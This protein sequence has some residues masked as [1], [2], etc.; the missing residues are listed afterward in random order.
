MSE[1]FDIQIPTWGLAMEEGTI[2]QWLVSE[3]DSLS[4]GQEICEIE[5]S[6]IANVLEA[7]KAGIVRRILAHEG[8]TLPCQ[9]PIAIC[10]PESASD[11]D[12][13]AYIA[14]LGQATSSAASAGTSVEEA[15][16]DKVVEPT[17]VAAAPAPAAASAT[18]YDIPESL[19][20]G[21]DDSKVL[22]MPRARKLAASLAINLNQV[23]GTGR[24]GRISVDDV[25]KA[26]TDAGGSVAGGRASAPVAATSGGSGAD[27]SQVN[28][29]PIARRLAKQLG[30]N[31]NDCQ[32]TGSRGRVAKSDVEAAA[33]RLGKTPPAAASAPAASAPPKGASVADASA[34]NETEE[35]PYT[36][37]RKVIGDRLLASKHSAPHVRVGLDCDLGNLLALRKMIND[38]APQV[39]LSV[40]DFVIK[41][42]A[43]ALVEN[44]AVN[45]QF[46]EEKA[47]IRRFK[48]AEV[49]VAVAVEDG[50][51]TPIVKNA[52]LKSVSEISNEMRTLVT[53][54]KAG[55]LTLDEFQGGTFSVSNLG[56]FGI[57]SFDSI[58]NPPQC[59]ILSVGA[60][61]QRVV[62]RNGEPTVATEMSLVLTFDHRAIDGATAAVFMQSL[63]KY[64]ETPALMIA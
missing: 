1:I 22:A 20:R 17:P 63:K 50:L 16:P 10:A 59:A 51:I 57:V 60:G 49:A 62:V 23:T 5:T 21:D 35:Q 25:N 42:V 26:I 31:L 61:E 41:A 6:K 44:P 30:V 39:K 56:M 37:I 46:D 52:N 13:D 36:G 45:V 4:K 2:T 14:S 11:A 43:M 48:N 3:G 9:A 12:V 19:K 55:T 53:K 29:T 7:H 40:N 28:A 58:I 38:D 47:V 18:S 24:G 27:D 8:A 33:A 32:A 54:A 64:I 15:V 34:G